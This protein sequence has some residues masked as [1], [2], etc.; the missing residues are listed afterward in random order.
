MGASDAAG[1]CDERGDLMAAEI[2]FGQTSA[3]RRRVAALAQG[4][5]HLDR[6]ALVH[7]AIVVGGVVERQLKIKDLAGIYLAVPDER[8]QLSGQE[9]PNPRRPAALRSRLL[10]L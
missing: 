2:S 7:R 1:P 6:I 10:C 4:Q 8:D 9:A 3:L 5:E